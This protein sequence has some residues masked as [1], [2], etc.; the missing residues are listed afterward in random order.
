MYLVLFL[1]QYFVEALE[2]VTNLYVYYGCSFMLELNSNAITPDQ[3]A[4]SFIHKTCFVF[5]LI[6]IV[7][8]ASVYSTGR[9]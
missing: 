1:I 2:K 4:V 3:A 9:W 5:T 8:E 6:L 7:T